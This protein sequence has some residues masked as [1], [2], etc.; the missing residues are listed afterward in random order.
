MQPA[1]ATN[2]AQIRLRCPR[3]GTGI[4]DSQCPACRFVVTVGRGIVRALS[5]ESQAHL[6]G[7]MDEYE[8]IREAE[9][10]GSERGDFYLGLPYVDASGRDAGQWHVR[11]R[12]HDY[13]LRHLLAGTGHRPG[14][15]VLDLGAGNC[16][17][18]YGCRLRAIGRARSTCSPTTATEWALPVTTA[19]TCQRCFHASRPALASFRSRTTSSTPPCSTPL[20]TT[21]R[22]ERPC[23]ASRCAA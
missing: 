19:R 6:T 22:M 11:A 21:A 18:S 13:V 1:A 23:C 15:M 8:R 20:S 2:P 16:W 14:A 7:F 5:P 17:M 3:C 12:S 10:R 9:G 4:P